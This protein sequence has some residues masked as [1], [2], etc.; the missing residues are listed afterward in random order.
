M[1]GRGNVAALITGAL[2]A[3]AFTACATVEAPPPD[4][5]QEQITI[6]QKQLLELQTLQN[7]TKKK[8]DDQTAQV[9]TLSAQLMDTEPRMKPL[10]PAPAPAL[11]PESKPTPTVQPAPEKKPAPA[12]KKKTFKKKKKRKAVRSQA[13]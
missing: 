9:E 5:V 10:A 11:E 2:A 4:P 6:L 13:Q 8:L 12:K 7:E 3:A 1:R